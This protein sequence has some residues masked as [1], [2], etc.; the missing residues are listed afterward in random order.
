MNTIVLVVSKQIHMQQFTQAAFLFYKT[1]Q[2]IVLTLSIG[3]DWPEHTVQIQ[4]RQAD[5]RI[6]SGST[7]AG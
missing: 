7:K 1:K 4:I 6:W 2:N 3:T 5:S